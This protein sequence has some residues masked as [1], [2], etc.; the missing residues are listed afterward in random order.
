MSCVLCLFL[1]GW[2]LFTGLLVCV[3]DNINILCESVEDIFELSC[4]LAYLKYLY[5]SITGTQ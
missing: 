2:F 4:S 5:G 1:Y 3:L